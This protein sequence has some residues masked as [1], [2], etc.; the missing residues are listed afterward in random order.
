[1]TKYPNGRSIAT[2]PRVGDVAERRDKPARTVVQTFTDATGQ[3]CLWYA[4]TKFMTVKA[5]ANFIKR[6]GARASR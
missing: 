3:S 1:M 2:D 6:S 5:W 4:E